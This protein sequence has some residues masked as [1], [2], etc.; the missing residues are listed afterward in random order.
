[1]AVQRA[2]L[3]VHTEDNLVLRQ[4]GLHNTFKTLLISSDSKCDALEK[5]MIEK[6]C[7]GMTDEQRKVIQTE[8][9][10]YRLYVE[11]N[12]GSARLFRD[13]ESPWT[14]TQTHPKPKILFKPGPEEEEKDALDDI[15]ME[16]TEHVRIYLGDNPVLRE[17]GLHNTF[18]SVE[19]SS[20]HTV[21]DVE[22]LVIA[23]MVKGMTQ[24]QTE[25]I[26][27][28][29][30]HYRLVEMK[31]Q[32]GG[33]EKENVLS[34]SQ[35]P[36]NCLRVTASG[37][38]SRLLFKP[39]ASGSNEKTTRG[40]LS[41]LKKGRTSSAASADVINEKK[42]KYAASKQKMNDTLKIRNGVN[43]LVN[44]LHNLERTLGRYEEDGTRY[45]RVARQ[46][47]T[48]VQQ[49]TTLLP[50]DDSIRVEFGE[51]LKTL[52]LSEAA[53]KIGLLSSCVAAAVKRSVEVATSDDF[54]RLEESMD[55]AAEDYQ[56][57]FDAFQAKPTQQTSEELFQADIAFDGL[58]TS[59]NN[60]LHLIEAQTSFEMEEA[61]C[62]YLLGLHGF[63]R[64]AYLRVDAAM[65]LVQRSL[66]VLHQKRTGFLERKSSTRPDEQTTQHL[67]GYLL[68]RPGTSSS[69]GWK[70]R[71]IGLKNGN[72]IHYAHWNDKLPENSLSLEGASVSVAEVSFRSR[73]LRVV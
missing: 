65:P 40:K 73:D 30:M 32:K 72:L 49:Q 20:R 46:F 4:V 43:P 67:Q 55:K 57:R 52:E 35:K 54:Q 59:M 69:L 39:M 42:I 2:A 10:T 28:Q 7:K 51:I 17:V 18:K 45:S 19:I 36:W 70:V 21:S 24:E 9:R 26:Q 64:Q 3:R 8:C 13:G 60:H 47:A 1:M 71:W 27:E 22:D 34:S 5:D 63:Y 44:H 6:M 14:T 68:Y 61:L 29:V 31:P 23:K 11:V 16:D 12:A 56:T 48:E 15:T 37:K 58:N 62:S 25:L 38:A 66:S 33:K 53:E 41:F 50:F